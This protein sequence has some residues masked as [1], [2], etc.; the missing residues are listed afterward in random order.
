MRHSTSSPGVRNSSS[1]FKRG[2]LSIL[3][4]ISASVCGYL[5]KW[6]SHE[7]TCLKLHA[8]PT[9]TK[10]ELILYQSLGRSN[11]SHPQLYAPA[12]VY[13][14]GVTGSIAGPSATF[15]KI[16]IIRIN[17]FFRSPPLVM[18]NTGVAQYL[19]CL[20]L[21]PPC[22]AFFYYPTLPVSLSHF[23][24]NFFLPTFSLRH[25]FPLFSFLLHPPP[26]SLGS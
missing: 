13:T 24:R 2:Y 21:I 10:C 4:L 11:V 26:L 14:T 9:S 19:G 7:R 1:I 23:C 3:I 15:V 18:P 12:S 25:C 5:S 8:F 6:A 20:D 22:A 17:M 16:T